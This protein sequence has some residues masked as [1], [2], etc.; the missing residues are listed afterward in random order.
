MAGVTGSIE[1]VDTADR[2]DGGRHP[3]NDVPP[4][5]LGNVRDGLDEHPE[6][7]VRATAR[8]WVAARRR[9]AD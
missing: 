7:L 3:I 2:L 9:D 8:R 5:T 6:M 1:Q 4:A